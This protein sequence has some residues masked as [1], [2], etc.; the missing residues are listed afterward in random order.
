MVRN[1]VFRYKEPSAIPQRLISQPLRALRSNV[2]L[3]AT[4]NLGFELFRCGA[5]ALEVL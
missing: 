5:M 1:L 2:G 4:E 3:A